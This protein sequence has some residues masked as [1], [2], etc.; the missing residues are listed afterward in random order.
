[1][2]Y[3][4]DGIQDLISGSY[5]P[6]DVYLIRGLGEGNYSEVESISDQEGT[7]LVHHPVAMKR[8]LDREAD[9]D[10]DQDDAMNDRVASFGSWAAM[11]D[12]D[13]DGDLDMLI[14]AFDG[15]LFR[16][17]NVGT[18]SDPKWSSE[19]VPVLAS[20]KPLH[21]HHHANPVVADWN[22]DGLQDLVV[23]SGNGSVGWFR[24]VGSVSKPEFDEWQQLIEGP[25]TS[26]FVQQYLSEGVSR[27]PGTRAQICVHDYNHDG[28]LDL[29][30]G[31]YSDVYD[32]PKQTTKQRKKL[33][34]MVRKQNAMIERILA[35]QERISQAMKSGEMTNEQAQTEMEQIYAEAKSEFGGE[36]DPVGKLLGE[37]RVSGSVWLYLRKPSGKFD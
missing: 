33:T 32:V 18:R 37:S 21:V 31:D 2:D 16:R 9:S 29:L 4:N 17:T 34:M 28:H 12:W 8:Y 6:G 10:S 3:D 36:E 25:S 35:A 23:G 20:G 13:D 26:I 7:P 22:D 19:S 27:A 14:G 24:N 11:M 1:V 15:S 5:D 30:V